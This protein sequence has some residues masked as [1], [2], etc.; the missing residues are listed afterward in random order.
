MESDQNKDAEQ[1]RAGMLGVGLDNSDG[2]K[3]LTKGENFLLVG[4]SAET[5]ERMQETAVKINEKLDQRGK[6][7]EDVSGEEFRDIAMEVGL[8]PPKPPPEEPAS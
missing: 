3:R 4:G 7:L 8:T 5:H 6:R 2:H 1:R